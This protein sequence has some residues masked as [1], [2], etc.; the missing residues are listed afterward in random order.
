MSWMQDR[1][2][3]NFPPFQS[4]GAM[5]IPTTINKVARI[6]T[7]HVNGGTGPAVFTKAADADEFWCVGRVDWSYSSVPSG[8]KLTVAYAGATILEIDIVYAGCGH[9]RFTFPDYLHN[10]FVKNEELTVTLADGGSTT[11][12]LTVRYC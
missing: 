11:Q 5:Q 2:R 10:G 7:E 1:Q 9:I 3:C 4:S 6:F 12:K 8:G